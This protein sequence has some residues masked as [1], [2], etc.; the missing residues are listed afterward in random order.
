MPL[1]VLALKAVEQKSSD[2][3]KEKVR[4]DARVGPCTGKQRNFQNFSRRGGLRLFS[5]SPLANPLID[6]QKPKKEEWG[7]DARG[8]TPERRLEQGLPPGAPTGR[9]GE[10]R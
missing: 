9:G 6:S 4:K 8:K 5:P 10:V 1:F 3:P 2:P 7:E